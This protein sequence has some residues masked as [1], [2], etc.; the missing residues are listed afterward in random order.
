M[1]RSC[2]ANADG[3]L[4]PRSRRQRHWP[5]IVSDRVLGGLNHVYRVGCLAADGIFV[6]HRLYWTTPP[7]RA[8]TAWSPPSSA[9]L[10]ACG[11]NDRGHVPMMRPHVPGSSIGKMAATLHR[12]QHRKVERVDIG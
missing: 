12:R 9:R 8:A 3:V 2:P 7:G 6:P 1:S 5:K 10:V 4:T 11:S